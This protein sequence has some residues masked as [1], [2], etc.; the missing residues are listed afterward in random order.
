MTILDLPAST[1]DRFI[2]TMSDDRT[3]FTAA[4]DVSS[5]DFY[6]IELPLLNSGKSETVGKLCLFVPDGVIVDAE[7]GYGVTELARTTP[8][9]FI[10]KVEPGESVLYIIIAI[11]NEVGPGFRTIRAVVEQVAR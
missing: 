3:A 9:I 1:T 8:T 7:A 2:G 11:A 10:F 4:A 6:A 5:G